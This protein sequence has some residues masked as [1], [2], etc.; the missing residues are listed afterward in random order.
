MS[1][2]YTKAL[3]KVES[4]LEGHSDNLYQILILTAKTY[5]EALLKDRSAPDG[6]SD[7]LYWVLTLMAK[8]IWRLSCKMEVLLMT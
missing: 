8:P 3:L 6:H 4:A 7:S 5:I 2:T 1:K